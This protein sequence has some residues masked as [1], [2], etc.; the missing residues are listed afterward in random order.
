MGDDNT[1]KKGYGIQFWEDATKSCIIHDLI[2]RNHLLRAGFKAQNITFLG[3]GDILVFGLK[4][5][6]QGV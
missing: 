1:H 5:A 2:S 6:N 3:L 4:V